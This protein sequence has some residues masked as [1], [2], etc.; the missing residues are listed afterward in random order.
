MEV[1]YKVLLALENV[2][3]HAWSL[4][5]VQ[6]IIGSSSLMFEPTPVLVSGWTEHAST[7]LIGRSTLT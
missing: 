3:A 2:H 7:S 1:H 6:S 5:A 4:D